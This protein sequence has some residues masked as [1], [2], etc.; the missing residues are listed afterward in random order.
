[1]L[2]RAG[3]SATK[4]SKEDRSAY[5]SGLVAGDRGDRTLLINTFWKVYHRQH[6]PSVDGDKEIMRLSPRQAQL[7]AF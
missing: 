2:I 1:M 3:L 6:K 4:W 7:E 5:L